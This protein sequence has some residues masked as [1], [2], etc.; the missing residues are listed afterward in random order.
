MEVRASNLTCFT[1]KCGL[2]QATHARMQALSPNLLGLS[3]LDTTCRV[4]RDERVVLCLLQHADD[5]E[6]VVLACTSLV[7]SSLD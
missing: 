2:G 3:R 6:A 5:E 7:F 1:V 4:R